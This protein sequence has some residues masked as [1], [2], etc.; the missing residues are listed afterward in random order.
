[1]SM[2]EPVL[3]ARAGELFELLQDF[4][5]PGRLRSAFAVLDAPGLQLAANA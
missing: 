5:A 4:D 2:A 3:G 1:M